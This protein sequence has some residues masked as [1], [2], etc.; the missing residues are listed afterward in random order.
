MHVRLLYANKVQFSSVQFSAFDTVPSYGNI[1][2]RTLVTGALS[3][4]YRSVSE[5][6]H[7]TVIVTMK[8]K[9]EA[10]NS[11]RIVPFSMTLNDL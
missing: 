4:I 10:V 9:Y 11:F 6:I 3:P 1:P 7:D 5:K 2:T 8:C